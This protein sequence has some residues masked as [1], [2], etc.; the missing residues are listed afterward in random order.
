ME[1]KS[2][3]F[4]Q[5]QQKLTEILSKKLIQVLIID[6]KSNTYVSLFSVDFVREGNLRDSPPASRPDLPA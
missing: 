3:V 4:S 1:K 5:R 2:N 6:L